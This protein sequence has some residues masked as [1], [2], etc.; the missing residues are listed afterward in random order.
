LLPKIFEFAIIE[1]LDC[2]LLDL[3]ISISGF[4]WE[5]FLLSEPKILVWTGGS[6]EGFGWIESDCMGNCE[7]IGEEFL[8]ESLLRKPKT[9]Y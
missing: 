5:T 7:G 1:G 6:G 8:D 9:T 3:A 2:E 4:F